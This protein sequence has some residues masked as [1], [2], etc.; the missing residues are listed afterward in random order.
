MFLPQMEKKHITLDIAEDFDFSYYGNVELMEQ[1]WINLLNNAIKFTQIGGEI[2]IFAKQYNDQ[3]IIFIKD[4][5]IGMDKDTSSHIFEKYYQNDTANIVKGNGIGLAVVKRI[6][7]LCGGS[8]E[9]DST[10]G[11]GSLFSVILDIQKQ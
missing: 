5:G 3:L 11:S 8:I 6:V 10:L 4:N 7:E 1:I 2:F 9:V